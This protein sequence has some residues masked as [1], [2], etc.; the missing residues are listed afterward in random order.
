[1]FH[2]VK[3]FETCFHF[4]NMFFHFFGCVLDCLLF[5]NGVLLLILVNRFLVDFDEAVAELVEESN[6][7]SILE[8]ID[9]KQ[10]PK[11]S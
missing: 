5:G 4:K 3:P 9:H 8:P 1:M 6:F 7:N 10:N 2:H 11:I